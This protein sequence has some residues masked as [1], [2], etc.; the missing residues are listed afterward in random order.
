[1]D[2]L[3]QAIEQIYLARD[4]TNRILTDIP[5][6]QWFEFPPGGV[7]HV[8]WQ[9]GHLAMAQYRLALERTRDRRDSD[10]ELISDEFLK[11]FGRD[12]VPV[13]DPSQYPSAEEI[14]M[15]FDRVHQ[16][17]MDEIK[18]LTPEDLNADV[19]KPHPLVKTRIWSLIWCSHHEMI[20]AGQIALIRRQLGAKPLW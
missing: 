11:V 9:V 8:A 10:A 16:Q 4:Y 14:L 1:M 15:T 17:T 3:E 19:Y 2:A 5:V 18:L 20:H 13:A 12:S 6:S 7:S